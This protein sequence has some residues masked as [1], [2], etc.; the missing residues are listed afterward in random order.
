MLLCIFGLFVA[1]YDKI[2]MVYLMVQFEVFEVLVDSSEVRW[3]VVPEGDD[4]ILTDLGWGRLV[5]FGGRIVMY[6]LG[7]PEV[8]SQVGL[9]GI[10]ICSESLCNCLNCAFC[11]AVCLQVKGGRWH[12]VNIESFVEF[13]KEIG[14][15]LGSS[16][17][18]DFLGYSMI[19]VDLT[20]ECLDDISGCLFLFHWHWYDER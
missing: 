14:D 1:G 17:R 10:E 3:L 2:V 12:E 4:L 15:K 13:S 20:Y 5:G 18:D 19:A 7:L 8:V 16:I 9:F 11:A 6:I